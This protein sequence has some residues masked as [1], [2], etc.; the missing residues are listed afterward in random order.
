M[1]DF[2]RLGLVAQF[3]LRD[4]L[5]SKL[6]LIVVALFA[7]GSAFGSFVFIKLY[8]QAELAARQLI[9]D[10]TG[11]SP[12]AVELEEIRQQAMRG[13]FSLLENESLKNALME[14]QPLAIFF[15]YASL[16]AVPL[17]V[18][19]LSAGA[20]AADIQ[21]GTARFSLFRCNRPTWAL[22]KT[23]G[24]AGL[25]GI[26]L[27]VAATVAGV[28]GIS[29]QP[30]FSA[31]TFVALY[32]A[33]MRT[34]IYGLCYLAIY[35]GLSLITGTPLQARALSLLTLIGCG[36]GHLVLGSQWAE[37]ELPPLA[38]LRWIF[39][40]AHEGGLWLGFSSSFFI[41]ALAL[42]SIGAAALSAGI[43]FFERKDA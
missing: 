43:W 34:W 41:A 14:L 31:T 16:Q 15:G 2:R 23:L 33:S 10:Q 25:L 29:L 22:G 18:L 36:I 5:R 7:A 37:E 30:E 17:L 6:A 38:L 19:A 4:A 27:L 26:G 20:H 21:S 32:T 9:A 8:Q 24:H 28:L 12:D 1:I 39:P 3:E 40:G 13:T 35:S 11:L 42:L